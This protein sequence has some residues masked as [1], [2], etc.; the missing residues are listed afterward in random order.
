VDYSLPGMNGLEILKILRAKY[1]FMPII[2]LT[3]QG[4][5]TVAVEA[6]KLG[7]HDYL[8]KASVNPE[9]LH[10]TIGRAI[11]QGH[12]QSR[13]AG[14]TQQLQETNALKSAILDNTKH[15]IVATD[16]NGIVTAF[17]K[18]TELASGYQATD[19]IG[20]KTP[21]VWH[22]PREVTKRAEILST[23][24]GFPVASDFDVFVRKASLRGS[25]ENE[26]TF[27][28]E[29]GARFPVS[30]TVT[31]IR[32]DN[33]EITGYLYVLEDITKRKEMERLKSEFI[34]MV[35]HELRTPLTSIRGSLGLIVGAMSK[36]LPEKINQ[37]LIIAHK[38]C[39]RL[40]TLINDILDIDKIA[41]GEMRFDMSPESLSA[42]VQQA[43]EA[44]HPYAS[45]FHINIE[46][47]PIPSGV[48]INVDAGRFL[49]TVTNLLSNASKFSPEGGTV[50]VFTAENNGRIRLNIADTGPGIPEKYRCHIF[51]KFFQVDSSSTRARSG[52]GLGL[53]IAKAIIQ[54]MKGEIGFDTAT[55]KGTT[56]WIEF[57]LATAT[58]ELGHEK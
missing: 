38:N 6:I 56:F 53:H 5:E 31:P 47:T 9:R 46:A 54:Q 21:I 28:C 13:L 42:L 16:T 37:L 3:G 11:K 15:M 39:E 51:E 2:L 36:D 32:N 49:Q 22:D 44:N 48:E 33:Y 1:P 55:G 34:S 43:I 25:D 14:T 19:I 20:K 24:L 27:I 41:A 29:N 23:E 7:A 35:S 8:S 18:A 52:S 50:K 45:K 57:P 30:L 4:S 10:H 17:N 40:I 26:W 58:K 12:M